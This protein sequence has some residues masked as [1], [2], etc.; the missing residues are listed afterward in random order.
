MIYLLDDKTPICHF[1][2]VI[3]KE[4][5]LDDFYEEEFDW[6]IGQTQ[7]N[8]KKIKNKS[9]TPEEIGGFWIKPN[10]SLL[11]GKIV[12]YI[13]VRNIDDA[14]VTLNEKNITIL[15]G[16]TAYEGL[17][18]GHYALFQHTGTVFAFHQKA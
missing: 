7:N 13:G 11:T 17:G 14:L 9:K 10:D 5:D 18:Q 1:D 4:S 6:D 3:E 16:K 2:I 15:R 12:P 8:Y